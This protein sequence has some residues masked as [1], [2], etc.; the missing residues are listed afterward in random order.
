MGVPGEKARPGTGYLTTWLH[1][2]R[3]SVVNPA[4]AVHDGVG[5]SDG[6]SRVDDRKDH[7]CQQ[8]DSADDFDGSHAAKY[9][10][11]SGGLQVFSSPRGLPEPKS[12]VAN[13]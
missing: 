5:E 3:H 4:D 12:A 13:T 11:G 6:L 7:S 2:P 10:S 9:R 8:Q 1:V